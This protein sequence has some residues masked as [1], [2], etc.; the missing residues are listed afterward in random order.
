MQL[1]LLDWAVI[2]LYCGVVLVTG[3]LCS[4]KAGLNKENFFVAG[5]KLHWFVAG[6]SMA[7][8][9][10]ASDTPLVVSGL[11]RKGGIYEN[12]IWWTLILSGMFTVFFFSGLWR[13]SNM[14]TDIQFIEF[15]YS[16]VAAKYLRLGRVVFNLFG[17]CVTIAWTTVAIYKLFS[18]L[19][20]IP[21][22]LTFTLGNISYHLSAKMFLITI[23]VF[24]VLVYTVFSGLWGV[25][26]TDMIQF[27]IAIAGAIVLAVISLYHAGGPTEMVRLALESSGATKAHISFFPR[28]SD[29]ANITVFTFGV[30]V[31]LQWW[32]NAAGSNIVVQRLLACKNEKNAALSSLWGFFII[33]VVRSWPWIIV[34]VASL[35]YFPLQQGEDHE[36]V[37]SKMMV[38]F[39]PVGLRGLM[40]ASFLAAFMSTVDSILNL[41]SSYLVN[42]VYIPYICKKPKSE[43]HYIFISRLAIVLVLIL[44]IV[45]ATKIDSIT[46]AWKY[47]AEVM[48]GTSFIIIIRWFWWRVNAWSE[49][50]AIVTSFLIANICRFIPVINTDEYFAV[51]FSANLL[52]STVIWIIVTLVTKPVCQNKLEEFF[53]QVQPGGWWKPLRQKQGPTRMN[54]RNCWTGWALSVISLYA[55]LFGVGH[56]CLGAYTKGVVLLIVF[57]IFGRFALQ[58]MKMILQQN[59][60]Y[61]PFLEKTNTTL[62]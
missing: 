29:A 52:I 19:F 43:K 53:N 15:R 61:K 6:T 7:A 26:I 20:N 59:Q 48:A 62:H 42:D 41:A 36:L 39:L 10:F 60:V 56:L 31:T 5:R 12:W 57:I 14:L 55:A 13:R 33:V 4:S 28:F 8:T 38:R 30:Y 21:D 37:Y 47:L 1:Q 51:R 11:V 46:L 3:L 50:S 32:H 54:L 23:Q 25:V 17:M 40:V 44:S 27:I 58:K 49:I 18:V 35:I 34:G 9:F 16:G 2:I 45:A 24:V 22:I